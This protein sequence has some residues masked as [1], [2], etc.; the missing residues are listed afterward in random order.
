MYYIVLNNSYFVIDKR[1]LRSESVYL[2]YIISLTIRELLCFIL[3]SSFSVS[4]IRCVQSIIMAG[5]VVETSKRNKRTDLR[6]YNIIKGYFKHNN[7]NSLLRKKT[8]IRGFRIFK[9]KMLKEVRKYVPYDFYIANL[10]ASLW[11]WLFNNILSH[12]HNTV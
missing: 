9:A 11:N 12:V 2:F 1:G 6:I 10:Q 4:L 3:K 7:N 8:F 5:W